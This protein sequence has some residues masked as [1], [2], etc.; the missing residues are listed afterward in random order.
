[1]PAVGRLCG[2]ADG[3]EGQ[4]RGDQV[5][6]GVRRLGEQ[7][8]A[9]GR[10]SGHELHRDQHAGGDDRDESGAA[11]RAHGAKNRTQREG[12]ADGR[13]FCWTLRA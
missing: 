10:D 12:P 1:M 4:Q 3:H 6:A 8:E 2:D 5:G 11:L 7:A 13:P 9:A